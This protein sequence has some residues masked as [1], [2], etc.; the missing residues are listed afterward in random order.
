MEDG[1]TKI[2]VANTFTQDS[3]MSEYYSLAENYNYRVHS[4][5]VENRHGNISLH[6]VPPETIEKMKQ[7][8]SVKL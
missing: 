6:D 2:V 1:E 4:L 8:F 5:I 7:R 3:E